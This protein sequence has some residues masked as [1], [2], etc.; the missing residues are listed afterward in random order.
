M[1]GVVGEPDSSVLGLGELVLGFSGLLGESESDG[2]SVGV[3]SSG[4]VSVGVVS[5]G[6][7]SGEGEIMSGGAVLGEGVSV[8]VVVVEGVSIPVV[9]VTFLQREFRG[10]FSHK[11]CNS[12]GESSR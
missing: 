1:S 12:C 4:V 2:V 11:L 6:V 3:V 9:G 10:N 8:G 5:S 7:V